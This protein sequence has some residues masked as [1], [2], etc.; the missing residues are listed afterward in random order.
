MSALAAAERYALIMLG[1]LAGTTWRLG[2]VDA[3][4]DHYEQV[5]EQMRKAPVQKLFSMG[6]FLTGLADAY[7]ARS[8]IAKTLAAIRE[9]RSLLESAGVPWTITESDVVRM[10]MAGG[11]KTPLGLQGMFTP[12]SLPAKRR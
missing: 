9:G 7:T 6:N 5:I 8:E 11:V 12:N 10:M 1:G 2:D 3:A 4:I